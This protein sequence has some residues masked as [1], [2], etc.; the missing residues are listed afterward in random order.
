MVPKL[1][2]AAKRGVPTKQRKEEFVLG[3][4]PKLRHAVMKNVPIR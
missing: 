1:R 4:V 3:M 2:Y